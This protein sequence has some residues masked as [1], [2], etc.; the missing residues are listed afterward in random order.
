MG[1]FIGKIWNSEPF[2][3]DNATLER[4]RDNGYDSKTKSSPIYGV[5]FK[6]DG[7]SN[8]GVR[9]YDAKNLKAVP[10]I[11]GVGVSE[12]NDNTKQYTLDPT[13]YFIRDAIDDFK[14]KPPFNIDIVNLNQ[15]N[16][17]TDVTLDS[18]TNFLTHRYSMGWKPTTDC[19]CY[20]RIPKFY[21]CRPQKWEF[22]VS[23]NYLPGFLPSPMHY[24]N[25]HM[26]NYAFI[27]AV[28]LDYK[29]NVG[30]MSFWKTGWQGGRN[31]S[32]SAVNVDDINIKQGAYFKYDF[33]LQGNVIYE[34]NPL[35]QI[36]NARFLPYG[37]ARN[38]SV[39]PLDYA[40]LCMLYFL[41]Y[42][43]YATM[44]IGKMAGTSKLSIQTRFQAVY[45]LS[46]N[47]FEAYVNGSKAHPADPEYGLYQSY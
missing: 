42:I 16:N 21:Y 6:K 1:L 28:R 46:H 34:K 4:D 14:D 39:I 18:N 2:T 44:D 33:L 15:D 8:K 36:Y 30:P 32:T 17:M 25:G 47:L 26:Y 22:L 10:A 31:G 20:I 3:L 41:F 37:L 27:S 9:L 5:V 40:S 19:N 7:I 12:L 24:R 43:K 29:N 11:H 45:P 13:Q 35:A 38:N 23:P